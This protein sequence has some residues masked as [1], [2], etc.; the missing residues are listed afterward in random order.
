VTRSDRRLVPPEHHNTRLA[1]TLT[2]DNS[3][4]MALIDDAIEDYKSQ[5]LGE[6]LSYTKVAEKHGVLRCTLARRCKG[7][8][9]LIEAYNLNKQKLSPLHKLELIDYIKGLLKR[10]LLPTREMTRRFTSKIG[11]CYIRNG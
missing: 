4:T 8:Q 11:N 2:R 9:A 1:P 10:G 6:Q 3:T 7:S 5:E